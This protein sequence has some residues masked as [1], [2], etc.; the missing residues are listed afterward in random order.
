MQAIRHLLDRVASADVTM[1]EVEG[2]AHELFIGL[3]RDKV[4]EYILQWINRQ[5]TADTLSEAS[6]RMKKSSS[7]VSVTGNPF[8]WRP[9][10]LSPAGSVYGISPSVPF[11]QP[12]DKRKL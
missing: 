5:L 11:T 1:H 7:L 8:D 3:E 9:T 6:D 12:C 10:G 4:T 2:G